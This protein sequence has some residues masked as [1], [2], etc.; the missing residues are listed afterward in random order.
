METIVDLYELPHGNAYAL[1]A[2]NGSRVEHYW[3]DFSEF[4]KCYETSKNEIASTVEMYQEYELA[5]RFE[6]LVLKTESIRLDLKTQ[7]V[8][9]LYENYWNTYKSK[10]YIKQ[11]VRDVITQL[12]KKYKLAVVSNFMVKCGIEQ[13]LYSNGLGHVFEFV[14]TSVNVGWKKPH[15]RIY[16]FSIES[17]KEPE[18]NESQIFLNCWLLYKIKVD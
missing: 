7:V 11:E 4:V 6:L 1:W 9:K 12:L 13:L 10:C 2:F 18:S 16:E 15:S 17:L 3:N 14:A 8:T 5:R